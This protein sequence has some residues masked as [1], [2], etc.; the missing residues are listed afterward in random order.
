MT[1]WP[2]LFVRSDMAHKFT[3]QADRHERIHACQQFEMLVMGCAAAALLA[4][5]GAGWWSLA[6][7]PLFY[8][9]YAVEWLIRV[10]WT[11][12]NQ[13][14]YRRLSFEQETYNNQA[15][16]NYLDHRR[17]FAWMRYVTK[18]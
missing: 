18:K 17:P 4:L 5:C 3:E 11:G 6:A 13:I 16:G 15:D 10:F 12:S 14:A 2:F 9:W 7:M 1:V 8:W